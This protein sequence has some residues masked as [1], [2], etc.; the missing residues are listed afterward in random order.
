MNWILN[1]TLK[2]I[3]SLAHF[4][5]RTR[6]KNKSIAIIPTGLYHFSSNFFL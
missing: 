5:N 2:L 6:E 3:I 4:D 1:K